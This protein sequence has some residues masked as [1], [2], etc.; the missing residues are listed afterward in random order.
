MLS[1]AGKGL[2]RSPTHLLL[3]ASGSG[4]MA[5]KH[6]LRC[7]ERLYSKK[8]KTLFGDSSR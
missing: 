4:N 1:G 6:A 2:A 7:L 8:L 5:S 3:E